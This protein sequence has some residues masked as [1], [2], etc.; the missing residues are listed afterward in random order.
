MKNFVKSFTKGLPQRFARCFIG[1]ALPE[2]GMREFL[3]SR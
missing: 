1:L 2:A 3:T